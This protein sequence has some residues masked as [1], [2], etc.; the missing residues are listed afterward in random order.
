MWGAP[1]SAPRPLSAAVWTPQHALPADVDADAL[2]TLLVRDVRVLK[3]LRVVHGAVVVVGVVGLEQRQHVARV[4]LHEAAAGPD[5]AVDALLSPLL[6]FN[7]G[8]ALHDPKPLELCIRD[9]RPEELGLTGALALRRLRDQAPAVAAKAVIAPLLLSSLA[10]RSHAALRQSDGLV[11]A[12]RAFFQTPRVLQ[13]GDVL[14]IAL[15]ERFP[16]SDA[17]PSSPRAV[18]LPSSLQTDPATTESDAVVPPT[19][20]VDTTLVFYRVE[21]LDPVAS[22]TDTARPS[23]LALQV[24]SE[25]ELLQTGSISAAA[26]NEDIVKSF[27][28]AQASS[29]RATPTGG[30]LRTPEVDRLV[31]MLQPSQLCDVPVSVLLSGPSGIGKTSLVHHAAKLLGVCVVE[32][33]FTELT[34]TT[35]L[36]LLDNMRERIAKAQALAP[37][38]LYISRFFAVDSHDEESELQLAAALAHALRE[39]SHSPS[40]TA[41]DTTRHNIP[42]IACVEDVT[43]VPKF[44]R[45]CFLYELAVEA[46]DLSTRLD[47]LQQLAHTT[48]FSPEVS[49]PDVA[50]RT[51]GRT[52]GE[53]V[54]LLADA[55]EEAIKRL[56]RDQ[57]SEDDGASNQLMRCLV[58]SCLQ[59][60]GGCAITQEDLET[61]LARQQAQASAARAGGGAA[62]IPNVKW[63]D[64]GGLDD[65]KD[66]IM[67]VVQLPLKHPELFSSGVR[68]R[69]GILL[70]EMRVRVAQCHFLS[71][72]ASVVPSVSPAELQHYENL[73]QQYS[74]KA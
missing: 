66:E 64:V 53:L 18:Q 20:S 61:A 62:S 47:I 57:E 42:L 7:L 27:R 6:A 55:G 5:A 48:A 21:S 41:S 8:C 33:P 71:A 49:M 54:A 65:V 63:E 9:A 46:P 70:D 4:W 74:S 38:V 68:Q 58:E 45:Q 24:S 72:L 11:A 2:T 12:L 28:A 1:C 37:C 31:G 52:C 67:D 36:Q 3:R 44:I 19:L 29:S 56:R 60:D 30:M 59:A 32:V 73:K 43:E 17:S 26:P 13:V 51:A 10:C 23:V 15:S 34:A 22:E 16:S 14:A 50:Q 69:S 40:S 25:T 39:L 35:E